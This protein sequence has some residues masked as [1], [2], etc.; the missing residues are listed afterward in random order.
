M[1]EARGN[2][3]GDQNSRSDEDLSSSTKPMIQGIRNPTTAE[4]RRQCTE[5]GWNQ[6]YS[7]QTCCKENDSIYSTDNPFVPVPIRRFIRDTEF[8]RKTQI[9]TVGASLIP[10]LCSS[11]QSTDEYGIVQ[12]ESTSPF[13]ILFILQCVS[14]IGEQLWNR[15]EMCWVLSYQSCSFEQIAIFSQI[16]VFTELPSFALQRRLVQKLKRNQPRSES[17]NTP[18]MGFERL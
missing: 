15:G 4:S 12:L 2:W 10:S 1:S 8:L 16:L 3:S 5:S 9:S 6:Q 17:V 7:H 13:M 11:S 14:L 18:A